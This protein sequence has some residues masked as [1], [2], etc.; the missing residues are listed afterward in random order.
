MALSNLQGERLRPLAGPAASTDLRGK[1]V[2]AGPVK[3]N[4]MAQSLT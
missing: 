1:T 2:I 4:V 3:G